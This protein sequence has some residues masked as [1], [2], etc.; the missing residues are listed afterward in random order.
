MHALADLQVA[1]PLRAAQRPRQEQAVRRPAGGTQSSKRGQTKEIGKTSAFVDGD[2]DD[3]KTVVTFIDVRCQR[4]LRP[5][6][7]IDPHRICFAVFLLVDIILVLNAFECAIVRVS[8]VVGVD[9]VESAF[10]NA[11]F[12]ADDDSSAFDGDALPRRDGW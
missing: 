4:S 7:G 5:R 10:D 8:V 1:Q 3:E 12:F 9:G 11:L 2:D 6:R